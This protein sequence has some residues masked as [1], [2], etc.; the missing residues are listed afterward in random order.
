MLDGCWLKRSGL[1]MGHTALTLPRRHP[2]TLASV[3]VCR[4]CRVNDAQR[5]RVCRRATS[6][7]PAKCMSAVPFGLSADFAVRLCAQASSTGPAKCLT[8]L[9]TLGG[10]VHSWGDEVRVSLCRGVASPDAGQAV[11]ACAVAAAPQ[12]SPAAAVDVCRDAPP[13]EHVASG[14][15]GRCLGQPQPV[16]CVHAF[17]AHAIP[18]L[19][20]AAVCRGARDTSPAECANHVMQQSP[21]S[22]HGVLPFLCRHAPGVGP[23]A[24]FGAL[25]PSGDAAS[26]SPIQRGRLCAGAI[27]AAPAACVNAVTQFMRQPHAHH[28]RGSRVQLTKVEHVVMLC[29]GAVSQR[30]VNATRWCSHHGNC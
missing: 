12:L 14:S 8:T 30:R 25:S 20:K 11:A 24:C 29:Q 6:L 23:A 27:N 4:R 26:L 13:C 3:L 28:K 15:S 22:D 18:E 7:A 19:V 16:Q 21:G 1:A 9:N 10:A 2:S 5:V 17:R